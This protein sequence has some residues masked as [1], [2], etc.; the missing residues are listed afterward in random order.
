MGKQ[1]RILLAVDLE[2]GMARLVAEVERYARALDAVVDVLHVS[3]PDPFIG[4]I[5]SADPAEQDVIDS[6]RMPR[7]HELR[8]EHQATREVGEALRQ[9]GV[10]IDQTLTVQGPILATILDQA[11]RS[12]ADLLMLGVHHHGALYRLWHGDTATGAAAEAPCAVLLIP[13]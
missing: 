11:T 3:D 9:R 13:V 8:A 12:E 5:K 4:Y 6:G 10:A 7:A 1:F 2:Q